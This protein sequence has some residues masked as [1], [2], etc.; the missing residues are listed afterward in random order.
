MTDRKDTRDWLEMKMDHEYAVE[1][2]DQCTG[3][4]AFITYRYEDAGDAHLE[5]PPRTPKPKT[6]RRT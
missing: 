6:R 1:L 2:E 4:Q 3:R 5:D